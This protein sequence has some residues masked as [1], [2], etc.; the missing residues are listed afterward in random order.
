MGYDGLCRRLDPAAARERRT[1]GEA[2]VVRLAMPEDSSMAVSD[3][4]RGEVRFERPQMDD[5]VLL[6]SDGFPTY[7]LANVVDDHLMG[8][9][10]V[11]R[12][13]EWLSSLPK[14]V[15]LY[16]SFGWQMP[17]FCHLPLLRN[18]DKSKI[19]KRKNP[20]SLNHYRRAGFLP[21]A[22]V[23]FLALM[24]FAMPEGKEEFTLQEFTDTFALE[25]ISLGGPVFDLEKLLWLNGRYLRRLSPDEMIG[26]LRGHLWSDAYLGEVLPLC[27][28]RVDTL[29]GF[30]EYASFFFLGEVAYDEAALRGGA[31]GAQAGEAS[32]ALRTLLEQKSTPLW[33]AAALRGSPSFA[34]AEGCRR[35][36]FM[37]SAWRRPDAPPPRHS[38]RP[39]PCSARRP[40]GAGCAAPPSAP[41]P[42]AP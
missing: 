1:A 35:R 8:I 5:Q 24:S 42:G 26:R 13:E 4:L 16:R 27:R 6:K 41:L 22:M 40:A 20:V 11:V 15:Q 21:E 10:H 7:H 17:V 28:E 37:T 31:E 12:A 14:H 3:L 18:A 23:N 32:K 39:W 29:E 34:E 33:N 25:R 36:T 2:C 30:F 9:T 19:S 38:S